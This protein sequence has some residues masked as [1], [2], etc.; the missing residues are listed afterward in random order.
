MACNP[1]FVIVIVTS[2]AFSCCFLLFELYNKVWVSRSTLIFSLCL[3]S[4][5]IAACAITTKQ[6]YHVSNSVEVIDK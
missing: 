3:Y 5:I 6:F 4:K 2:T 1:V